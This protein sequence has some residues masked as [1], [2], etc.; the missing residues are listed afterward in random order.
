MDPAKDSHPHAGAS[1]E[2][3]RLLAAWKDGD[4]EALAQLLP[5]VYSELRRL[6][7]AR[8]RRERPD[9]TLQAT[10]L[11]HEAWLRLM[12]GQLPDWR[13]RT[14]FFAVAARAMRRLLVD[15][16]RSRGYA[17]RGGGARRISL[18]AVAELSAEGSQDLIDLDE[19]LDRLAALDSRQH[20]VVELRF[21]GGLSVEETA[22]ALGVSEMTVKRDWR[23]ARAW[24]YAELAENGAA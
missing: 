22:A 20:Q 21:F 19:A 23:T 1:P 15:H 3:T 14:H 7:E 16:A 5:L 18:D 11:V 10:E 4:P 17:K 6:A 24:L 13:D 8:M 2:V 12:G 9:H